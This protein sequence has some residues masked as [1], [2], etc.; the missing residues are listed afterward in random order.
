MFR[1]L[2]ALAVLA[3][4]ALACNPTSCMDLCDTQMPCAAPYMCIQSRC[5]IPAMPAP[6]GGAGQ[7]P[8]CG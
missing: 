7:P 5:L 6:D 1:L 2:L 3:G 4:G 8:S